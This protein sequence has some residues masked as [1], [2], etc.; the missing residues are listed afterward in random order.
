ME[1]QLATHLLDDLKARTRRLIVD[2]QQIKKNDPEILMTQPGPGS[3]SVAQV[4]EHLVSYGVYYLPLIESK[5]RDAKNSPATYFKSGFLGAYFTRSMLPKNG[6]VKNKMKAPANHRASSDPDSSHMIEEFLEQQYLLLQLLEDAGKKD[7]NAI[8]IPISLTK[9][10]KLK[11]GD[12]F[13]FLI[14][15]QERHFVQLHR[16]L[17]VIAKDRMAA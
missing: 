9:L 6:E 3:W 12:V 17:E 11:L 15:H 4:L 7:L 10:I 1:K 5:L 13:G 14:A 16:A 8:R 2:L